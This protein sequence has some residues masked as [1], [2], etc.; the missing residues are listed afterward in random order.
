M[1]Y[2]ISISKI[3]SIVFLALL[4]GTMGACRE[5]MAYEAPKNGENAQVNLSVQT[6]I[7]Q[8]VASTGIDA[9]KTIDILAFKNG[10]LWRVSPGT[11]ASG[12]KYTATLSKS[13]GTDD[14]YVLMILANAD[15]GKLYDGTL[16]DRSPAEVQ[17]SLSKSLAAN[18]PLTF[19]SD[20]P[21]PMCGMVNKGQGVEVTEGKSLG[22]V[23]LLRA[24]A[25]VDIGIGTYKDDPVYG[26]SWAAPISVSLQL[27]ELYVYYPAGKYT[28]A[29][30]PDS[31]SYAA[32]G[33]PMVTGVSA[34]GNPDKNSKLDYST[35]IKLDP[36]I[37]NPS[38]PRKRYCSNTIF[39]PEAAIA[40]TVYDN[41]HT[42]RT[43]I[44]VGL[45]AT[46][47]DP[48]TPKTT[49]YFRIDFTNSPDNAAG[50]SVSDI[51]RNSLYRITINSASYEAGFDTPDAAYNAKPT[52]L[53]FRTTVITDWQDGETGSPSVIEGCQIGFN[54][55]NGMI[56]G[57]GGAADN[58]TKVGT[59][60]QSGNDYNQF[61]GESVYQY[62]FKQ[63]NGPI[64]DTKER[65]FSLGG[66]YPL[67]MIASSDYET[68]DDTEFPWRTMEGSVNPITKLTAFDACGNYTELGYND[69]RL[70]RLSELA[71][72]YLNHKSLIRVN[73][74]EPLSGQYWSADEYSAN[75][76]ANNI[77]P[78]PEAWYFN[79]VESGTLTGHANKTGNTFKIRC[80][81]QIT[82]GGVNLYK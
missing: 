3:I 26:D 72:I 55:V 50:T 7:A 34:P 69:W 30:L 17:Q 80:V 81:R 49:K 62:V 18:T 66:V 40:G 31:V 35:Y 79:F 41:R 48:N 76:P 22:S 15:R 23:Q 14:T 78:V 59:V 64:F 37:T 71:M 54:G 16:T 73:G 77:A 70:P 47:G 28:A 53:E 20:S 36:E 58:S 61:Y 11:L 52:G 68:A 27:Y 2:H 1:T 57:D 63:V 39:L 13:F 74:F 42:S 29:Y 10:K 51:L 46:K 38:Y 12:D 25:R 5:D 43:A 24:V 60:R 9:I 19:T 8:V 65:A 67:V 32:D 6:G 45:Y 21:I 56:T 75:Y 44:V 82:E 4:A 33:T